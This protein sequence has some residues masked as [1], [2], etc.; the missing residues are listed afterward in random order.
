MKINNIP[1]GKVLAF[2]DPNAAEWMVKTHGVVSE[3]VH[4]FLH[5]IPPEYYD[6][7]EPMKGDFVAL[8]AESYEYETFC[9]KVIHSPHEPNGFGG[10]FN[11]VLHHPSSD[12]HYGTYRPRDED[13]IAYHKYVRPNMKILTRDFKPFFMPEIID[14]EGANNAVI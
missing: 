13:D 11:L 14:R 1:D 4:D 12:R 7:C 9:Y 6:D 2:T 3:Y 5:I 8:L 10:F